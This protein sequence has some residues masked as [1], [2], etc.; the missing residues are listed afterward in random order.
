[1]QVIIIFRVKGI[2][3]AGFSALVSGLKECVAKKIETCGAYAELQYEN[4]TINLLTK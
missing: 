3:E 4:Q 2:E 1:L